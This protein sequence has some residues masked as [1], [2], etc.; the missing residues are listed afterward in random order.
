MVSLS[1]DLT[2][3]NSK[4]IEVGRAIA[5]A[6]VVFY[7]AGSMYALPKYGNA[8]PWSGW[9]EIGKHGVDLFFIISGFII[10]ATH[11]KDFGHPERLKTY[12]IRRFVRIY[13]VYWFWTTV[14]LFMAAAGLATAAIAKSPIDLLS[15]YSLIRLSSENP[16]L[17]VAWTLFH[18]VAFYAIFSLLILHRSFGIMA[19][20]VWG[21]SIV[22]S[23][24]YTGPD[25]PTFMTVVTDLINLEFF[26]GM[27]IAATFRRT[28]VKTAAGL[29]IIGVFSLAFVAYHN[30]AGTLPRNPLFYGV[31]F[32]L[33]LSGMVSLEYKKRLSVP[34]WILAI[35][36]ATFSIYLVHGMFLS[37]IYRIITKIAP[38][39]I[40]FSLQLIPVIAALVS[41]GI[42]Y[43]CYLIIERPA[44]AWMRNRVAKA[45]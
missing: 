30:H 19:L 40:P 14:F 37:V 31:P 10:F 25:Q 27:A 22:L 7:H 32:A 34:A 4:M 1:S 13:P 16:P 38:S 12:V 42:G 24:K 26:F 11:Q 20:T 39:S 18:E 15:A 41:I 45:A 2:R 5:A 36:A 29:L 3:F 6:A 28:G 43:I 33:L 17:W 44:L 35:G 21:L 23:S 8:V 9:G